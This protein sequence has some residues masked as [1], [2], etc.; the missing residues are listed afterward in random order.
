MA[1]RQGTAEG[2]AEAL[3]RD[4]GMLLQCGAGGSSLQAT[5]HRSR[6]QEM[7][8][9]YFD[10]FNG[11][12]G[13]M[14]LAALIS[15][16]LSVEALRAELA[17]LKLD[18]FRLEVRQLKKQGFAATKVDVHAKEQQGHRH[19]HHIT[20]II[21]GSDLGDAVKDRARRIFTRLAEAEAK[22]HGSTIEKVHFHEVGAIDAIVDIVGASIAVDLLSIDRIVCSPIPTG[23]GTVK[24]EH[25]L[26][27]VPAPATAELLVGVPIALSDEMAE[28]C[29]PTGAAILSTLAGSFGPLPPMRTTQI[30]YGAGTRD[31][32]TRPNLIRVF[33]GE[34]DT[35]SGL[36]EDEITVLEA[37]LDDASGQQIGHA[38]EALFA[39]GALDVFA[40][41]IQMKKN[42]PGVMLCVLASPEKAAACEAMIF[43]QT[44]TFG[45]R[46]FLCA[47][48]KLDRRTDTVATRYGPVRVKIGLRAGV[49]CMVAPEYEDCAA[50][51]KTHGTGLH[52]VAFAA[53]SAWRAA[54]QS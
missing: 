39:A 16:G 24:C 18:G 15:A 26:M 4:R 30:G 53:E 36:L 19:L 31:G 6:R 2:E 23:S 35:P 29:T 38:F 34:S 13:D 37:N 9:A 11:A 5:L 33:L 8:I 21:D 28:L 10:C 41:P 32:K 43:A 20:R 27:P 40:V 14:I 42:R 22:V 48:R 7:R 51:A 1:G 45:V 44:P 52:E 50:A 12:A 25:G 3:N 54:N 17:K 49:V 46:R 47:R